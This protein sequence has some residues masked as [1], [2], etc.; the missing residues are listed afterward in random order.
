MGGIRTIKNKRYKYY[1][2]V[3]AWVLNFDA[4]DA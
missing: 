2:Q 3:G 4:I 1:Y